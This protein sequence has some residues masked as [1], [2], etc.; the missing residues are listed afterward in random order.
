[1]PYIDAQNVEQSFRLKSNQYASAGQ[2]SERAGDL[3][4]W[5]GARKDMLAKEGRCL[6]R[7]RRQACHSPSSIRQ[8]VRNLRGR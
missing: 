2:F 8:F 1:M 3:G 7:H 4:Q 6:Q 5:Q